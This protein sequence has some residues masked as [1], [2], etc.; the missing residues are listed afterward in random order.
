MTLRLIHVLCRR[1]E[2]E[3]NSRAEPSFPGDATIDYFW[4][5]AE[6]IRTF[7]FVAPI[8]IDRDGNVIAGHGRLAASLPTRRRPSL[9]RKFEFECFSREGASQRL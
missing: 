9:S 3:T 6:S 7:G 1:N 5:L 4:Q 8:L 2:S